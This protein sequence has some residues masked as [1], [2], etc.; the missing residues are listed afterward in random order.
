MAV[1]EVD[2]PHGPANA[3]LH[4]ADEPRA[5]LVLGHGAAGGVTPRDLVAVMASRSRRGHRRA[6]RAALPR[7][8][9]TFA[10]LRRA[11]STP[12]G[13]P[14]SS[15]WSRASSAGC[16]SSSEAAPRARASP[17]APPRRPA[18]SACSASRSRCS[19][20]AGRATPAPSRLPELDAVTVPTLVVQG[21]RDRFGFR[22]RPASH[23]G[24]GAGRP[25]LETDLE[26]VAAAVGPGFPSVLPR[27][28]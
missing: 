24:A 26:A 23:G 12:P 14:W 3:H 2:T 5:A 15:T 18:L 6:R 9:A 19:R 21:E 8:R 28:G 7:R 25:Q 10:R 11:S 13:R 4:P 20:R 27:L 1:L 16:R 17:A 22:R